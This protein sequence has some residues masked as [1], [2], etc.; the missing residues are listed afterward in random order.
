MVAH[1]TCGI[2]L[3]NSLHLRVEAAHFTR[4]ARTPV[5]DYHM[6]TGSNTEWDV[7][8]A[9]GTFELGLR[10]LELAEWTS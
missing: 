6:L 3:K 5:R 7:V 10:D 8:F 4:W 2:I 1:G 9:A